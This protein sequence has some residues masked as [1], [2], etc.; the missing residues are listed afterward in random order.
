MA[1]KK[2]VLRG[3]SHAPPDL[4][5]TELLEAAITCFGRNGYF[6]TTIDH[7]AKEAG[8]S[9]GSVYRFFAK[10]EDVLLGIVRMMEKK[11]EDDFEPIMKAVDDPR[12]LIRLMLKTVVLYQCQNSDMERTWREFAFHPIAQKEYKRIFGDYRRDLLE[13]YQMGVKEGVFIEQDV[14]PVLDALMSYQEGLFQL[15]YALPE[16]NAIHSFDMSWPLL[17]RIL[18]KPE[19]L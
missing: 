14:A 8:L 4:R 15:S 11:F 12:E 9:K 19:L 10:K 7:I 13:L 16:F 17:E 3:S 1:N 5:K 18:I 6:G 2:R